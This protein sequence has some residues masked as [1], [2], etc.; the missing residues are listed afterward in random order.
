MVNLIG[1]YDKILFMLKIDGENC[2][3]TALGQTVA[4]LEDADSVENEH[5]SAECE[6]M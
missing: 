5:R 6:S 4:N 1:L 3:P 2:Q